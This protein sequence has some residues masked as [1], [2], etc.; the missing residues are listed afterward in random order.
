MRLLRFCVAIVAIT[1]FVPASTYAQF[2]DDFESYTVGNI[3][4]QG[5]WR[6]FPGVEISEVSTAQAFS[7]TQSLALSTATSGDDIGGFGSDVFVA[8]L[9]DTPITSGVWNLSYQLYVP[10]S[11]DGHVE[12]YISQGSIRD[13][14]EEGVFI[15]ANNNVGINPAINRLSFVDLGENGR[16]PARLL[17]D[18]WVEINVLIDLDNNT[19]EISYNGS[20][21]FTSAWD[22]QNPGGDIAIGGFNFWVDTGMTPG[23]V[24]LDDFNFSAVT[25]GLVGDVNLDD[26]V[27]CLDLDGYVGNIGAQAIGPLTALDIDGNGVL[28]A[29]DATT[30]I[31][32]L[33]ETSNGVMG[34]FPGDFNCDGTVDVLTDAFVLVGA[35]GTSVTAYSQGDADFNGLVDVLGDAFILVGNLGSTNNPAIN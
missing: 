25:S 22:I 3:D 30:H 17:L 34:T 5:P 11:F 12:M 24:F 23:T 8:N 26:A 27:D 19:V 21:F 31:T 6:D 20:V 28:D 35:L 10:S 1:T 4:G 18:Q 33:V 13:N 2:S 15:R 9:N 29:S 14:F 32:N 16:T 7:G